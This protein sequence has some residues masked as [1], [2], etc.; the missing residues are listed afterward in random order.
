MATREEPEPGGLE[1]FYTNV[2]DLREYFTAQIAEPALKKRLLIIHGVGGIGK[3][4]LLRI[5]R[6]N[7]RRSNTP[8]AL[9][10]GDDNRSVVAIL[11]AWLLDFRGSGIKLSAT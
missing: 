4:S 11:A 8:V 7:C 1:T 9:A 10:S 6:S 2:E 5:F 3:S